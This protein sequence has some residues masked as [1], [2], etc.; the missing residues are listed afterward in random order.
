MKDVVADEFVE[1]GE[2]LEF[3]L[4]SFGYCSWIFSDFDCEAEFYS[5]ANVII[6]K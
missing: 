5:H 2:V 4:S 6:R 1:F 3:V